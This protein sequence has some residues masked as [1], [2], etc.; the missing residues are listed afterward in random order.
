MQNMLTSKNLHFSYENLLQINWSERRV[1]LMTA[2][3]MLETN[4]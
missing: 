1:E 4:S 2:F 3:T